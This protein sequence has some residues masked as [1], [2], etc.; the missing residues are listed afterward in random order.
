MNRRQLIKTVGAA[1]VLAAVGSGAVGN[2]P[3]SL[4][5]PAAAA[6]G[7][8]LVSLTGGAFYTGLSGVA[9]C[10]PW[11]SS[12]EVDSSDNTE[13][14]VYQIANTIDG[15]RTGP[16]GPRTELQR[17]YIDQSQG[18]SAYAEAAGSEVVSTA[19]IKTFEGESDSAESAAQTALNKQTTRALLRIVETWNNAV[20]RLAESGALVEDFEE[21]VHILK[22]SSYDNHLKPVPISDDSFTGV[23]GTSPEGSDGYMLYRKSVPDSQLPYPP[24]EL[25]GRDKPMEMVGY[26]TTISDDGI[27]FPLGGQTQAWGI[28]ISIT[29]SITIEDDFNI[30]ADPSG[31]EK[32]IPLDGRLLSDVV[33]DIKAEYDSIQSDLSSVVSSTVQGLEQGTIDPSAVLTGDDLL[34]QYDPNNKRSAL[35]REAIAMGMDMPGDPRFQ[36]KVSHP[37]LEADS[38]W[39]D[40]VLRLA[41][42]VD[43]SVTG[44]TT[45][46]S[47][48]YNH[49]LIGYTGAATGEY[50]YQSLSGSSDLEILEIETQDQVVAEVQKTVGSGG[51]VVLAPAESDST[52]EPLS[53]SDPEFDKWGVNLYAADGSSWAGTVGD[54]YVEDGDW[55]IDSTLTE[56]LTVERITYTPNSTFENT[57]LWTPG[58]ASYDVETAETTI[59]LRR[60]INDEIEEAFSGLNIGGGGFFDG[61]PSFPGL[62]V[63]ESAVVLFL[64]LAGLN[65]ASG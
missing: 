59:D 6:G 29:D 63:I 1:G 57:S 49:A 4:T 5:R 48:D 15:D 8:C 17:D 26:C 45:I 44:P 60:K 38:L 19:A 22:D 50:Q 13:T 53:N 41:D 58:S 56:G 24:Q 40:L 64:M 10:L 18:Q 20:L 47:T 51:T 33:E 46:P 32:V 54:A 34:S 36:A 43:V 3:H 65:A 35:H 37:D 39:G 55:K 11:T 42:G 7:E 62:G 21:D 30:Y 28:S 23:E 27:V 16:D 25:E 14:F 31:Y 61:L 12:D 52:P 9:D 2:G